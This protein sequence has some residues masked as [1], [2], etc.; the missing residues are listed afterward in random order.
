M[1]LS[2]A[3]LRLRSEEV[4][5]L[6]ALAGPQAPLLL[7]ALLL[8]VG[9]TAVSLA[10]PLVMA[11]LVDGVLVY[12]AALTVAADRVAPILDAWLGL[13]GAD[14]AERL[15]RLTVLLLA[16]A[17]LRAG[18]G[19][20]QALS[21]AVAGERVVLAF[22]QRVYGHML[23]LSP[24]FYD[25]R[26]L[27]ELVSRLVNDI[28]Q[29][30]AAVTADLAGFAAT[31]LT[32]IGA[33]ALLFWQSWR[34]TLLVLVVVPPLVVVAR[35]FG[36]SMRRYGQEYQDRLAE[37]SAV[38]EETLGGIRLVQAFT[39]ED[40]EAARFADALRLLYGT[41]VRRAR[42]MAGFGTAVA[43][44]SFLVLVLTVWFGGREVLAGRLTTGELVAF[45]AYSGMVANSSSS[46]IGLYARWANALGASRRVFAVL[47]REPAI[48][49]RPGARPLG[50]VAGRVTLE[51]VHFA[52]DGRRHVLR[53]IEL[54]VTEGEKLALVGPSGAGK[55]TLLH[56]VARFYDP[57]AGRVLVDGTDIRDVA[58]E[59]LRRQIGIVSQETLL[60]NAS[61][62][63]NLRFGRPDATDAEIFAAA[64]AACAQEFVARL[65]DGYD[66]VVGERGVRL[67]VGER[68][69]L[70]I[71]RALLRDPRLLLLDE[72]TSSLDNESE[73]LVQQALERLTVGRTTIVIAHRLS[74][75]LGADRIAVL[76]EGRLVGI[77][78][79]EALV[80]GG[81]LYARLYE[82][83]LRGSAD[84][85]SG[86]V[87][88][89]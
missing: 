16:M 36:R 58:L 46:L 38:A 64:R 35:L 70:A 53:G 89:S 19:S 23:R 17:V 32:L 4:R 68:Q 24:A 67:S 86:A 88:W 82:L 31:S 8:T 60:F 41:A 25:D 84:A 14:A 52:Y 27:G 49:D 57:T 54:D 56:L 13:A 87:A 43:S 29:I 42:A 78:R 79:H 40:L 5:R 55:S 85:V 71:A 21:I 39:R 83:H 75:V 77:G 50:R 9:T 20:G 10:I 51:G 65:P 59:S 74:T 69:R 11:R 81:G 37:G 33:V 28:A 6:L 18:L 44:L 80:A 76:D 34:L 2:I 66:T 45:V 7:V 30:Q 62:A 12:D 22:R 47:A 26:R 63:D 73:V 15:N 61:V 48:S 3:G 72:A 1:G